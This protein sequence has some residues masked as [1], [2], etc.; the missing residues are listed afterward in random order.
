MQGTVVA[1]G[2]RAAQSALKDL[3]ESTK[4]YY[5]M[6]TSPDLIGL[7]D[8]PNTA[9][10]SS[11]ANPIE[12]ARL[13]NQASSSFRTI[14]LF[15]DSSSASSRSRIKRVQDSLTGSLRLEIVDINAH[16]SV[17]DAIKEL[18]ARDIDLI[19]TIP[20]PA[21]YKPAMVK[22]LLI[23]SL[24]KRIPV[25]G[26]SHSIVRAGSTFGIGIEPTTQG[27]RLSTLINSNATDQHLSPRLSVAINTVV[28]SRIDFKFN[29]RFLDNVEKTF[30]SD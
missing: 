14:G 19:W 30:G 15:Y 27:A 16:N 13:I 3:P 2:A 11:D 25:Y 22:S 6:V 5:C 12:E 1:I 20:D 10:I 24:K 28:A 23:E 26:F 17:S 29:D 21:V 7:T 8:R 9:G 4:L 18:L